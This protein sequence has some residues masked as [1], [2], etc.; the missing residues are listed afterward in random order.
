[1]GN[2]KRPHLLDGVFCNVRTNTLESDSFS[3]LGMI[4]PLNMM[5]DY[6]G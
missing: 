3:I 2:K 1:M 4:T 6:P 5:L